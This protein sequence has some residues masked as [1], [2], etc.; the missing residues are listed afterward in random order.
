MRA[1]RAPRR[2][3]A[4]ARLAATIVAALAAGGCSGPVRFV[5]PEADMPYY[6]RVGIVPFTSL[7]GDRASGQKVTDIFFTEVLRAH[8]AEVVEPGQFT[9]AM[10]RVR[11]GTPVENPWSGED[12]ARLGEEAKVQ[13]VFFGTVRDHE[14]FR[15]GQDAYP[16]LSLE[17]RL[18]DATT[19]RVVWSASTTR[20]GG[21]GT[22]IIGWIAGLFG[23]GEIRTLGELTAD[24]CRELLDTVPRGK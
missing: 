22:P 7:A 17:A 12:L 14:M 9:A 5:D 1:C 20:R 13:G 3:L 11:G 18:V 19:G 2:F 16:L 21:P 15:V 10:I 4:L 8:L 6:E 24:T 23:H